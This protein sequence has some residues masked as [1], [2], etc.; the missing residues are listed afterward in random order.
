MQGGLV[1]QPGVPAEATVASALRTGAPLHI[2]RSLFDAR[3]YC[4]LRAKLIAH[5]EA[6]LTTSSLAR[7]VLEQLHLARPD[8]VGALGQPPHAQPKVEVVQR[9]SAQPQPAEE[10]SPEDGGRR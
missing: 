2:N 1:L 3:R 9:P 7:Y 4:T 10:C 6:R 5:T 8:A